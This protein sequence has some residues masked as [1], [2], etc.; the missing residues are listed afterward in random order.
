MREFEAGIKRS[1]LTLFYDQLL[2]PRLFS[3]ALGSAVKFLKQSSD[4]MPRFFVILK[5][6]VFLNLWLKIT[7]RLP[8]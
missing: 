8:R 6:L 4:K 5:L 7:A 2:V 1:S 3:F